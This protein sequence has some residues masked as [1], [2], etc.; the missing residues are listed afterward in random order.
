[1]KPED[2]FF[3]AERK[4]IIN[5][6]RDGIITPHAFEL[7]YHEGAEEQTRYMI[8]KCSGPCRAQALYSGLL[9]S[10]F[11][12]SLNQHLLPCRSY[13]RKLDSYAFKY[14]DDAE[15]YLTNVVNFVR[16]LRKQIETSTT[17]KLNKLKAKVSFYILT[18]EQWDTADTAK[19][20]ALNNGLKGKRREEL[21]GFR[22]SLEDSKDLL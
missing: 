10:E 1:M 14:I 21:K 13:I 20:R 9:D 2:Q 6:A 3:I 22:R 18:G 19:M 15:Q 7:P 5:S 12:S 8:Y 4:L 17:K 16:W 11:G